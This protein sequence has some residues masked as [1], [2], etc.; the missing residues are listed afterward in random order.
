ME[1]IGQL[2]GGVAHDFNNLLTVI[3]S[4]SDLLLARCSRMDETAEQ[5][6]AI[7]EASDRAAGLTA[8]LL[9]FGRKAIIEPKILDL[10]KSV[11]AAA[12]LLRR[13]IGEDICLR[14]ELQSDLWKVTIDPVQL[15]QTL[16]NLAVNA[17]DA[18]PRGGDL[19]IRT[20]NYQVLPGQESEANDCSPG[21]YVQLTVADNGLG[22]SAEV[23]R[24]LFEPFYTTKGVGKGTGLG[25]ATVYGIVHQAGGVI[26]CDSQLG[27][28]TAF[29]IYLPAMESFANTFEE[30]APQTVLRGKRQCCWSKTNRLCGNWLK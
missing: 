29:R 3:R 28:G 19:L 4:Y 24:H 20:C 6:L 17:R 23:K 18:M 22:M 5:L 14:T 1:A 9:A 25:L 16:M 26:H 7:R 2:A 27:Q 21:A 13:L 8:Q 15:E 11:E 30:I 12:R 10:N